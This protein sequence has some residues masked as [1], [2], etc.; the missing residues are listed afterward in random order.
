MFKQN[1]T[2]LVEAVL[3]DQERPRANDKLLQLLVWKR[4]GLILAQEQEKLFLSEQIADPE[5]I[6]R[7]R[8]KLNEQGRYL[9][10]KEV[11]EARKELAEETKY[12][13]VQDKLWPDTL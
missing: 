6:R 1:V 2:S 3:R 7:T 5:T 9:P 12:E 8:Q 10:S 4:Q 11:Q 13:M